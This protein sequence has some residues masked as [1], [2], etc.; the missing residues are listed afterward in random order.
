M[1]PDAPTV[2]RPL[3][4][5]HSVALMLAR[6]P[7]TPATRYMGAIRAEP[8]FFSTRGPASQSASMLN[9]RCRTPSCR[10]HAVTSVSQ[11]FSPMVASE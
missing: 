5:T 2:T 1:A 6:F 11:R 10:K 9:A 3:W 4:L 8:T 7:K